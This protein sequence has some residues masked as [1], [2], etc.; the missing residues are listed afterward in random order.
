MKSVFEFE[1]TKAFI[2]LLLRNRKHQ[3]RRLPIREKRLLNIGCGENLA[4]GFINLDVDWRRGL[5]IC[6]DVRKGLPFAD[7]EIPGVFSEHCL[8]HIAVA[9]CAAVIREVF[10]ILVP[11]GRFRLILP[12]AELYLR[13]YL[14]R[15][16]GGEARF[17]FEDASDAGVHALPITYVNSVFR[18]HGHQFA[19]DF[20]YTQVLLREAG[21]ANVN[22][23]AYRQGDD[24]RLL[25][26][27]EARN[28]ESLYVEAM[29][30]GI[31]A[32][33]E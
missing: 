5:D 6:W 26:D 29:K 12:D 11:G 24:P 32:S 14:D 16:S 1:K 7:N 25:I 20:A 15:V 17:P 23:C 3:C 2:G 27:T 8:E 10:R 13:A 31:R 21:F 28:V 19:Y 18:D 4:S 33:A 30:P 22:R 9:E